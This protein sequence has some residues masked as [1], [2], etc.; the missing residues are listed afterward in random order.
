MNLGWLKCDKRSVM[1]SIFSKSH[2]V[3]SIRLRFNRRT[4]YFN[5]D[6]PHRETA[7]IAGRQETA[8]IAGAAVISGRQE[9]AIIAERQEAAIIAGAAVIIAGR[10]ET[11]I[12]AE[13]SNQHRRM[14]GDSHRR[15]RSSHHRR[16]PGNNHHRRFR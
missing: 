14:P 1:S 8:I 2:H 5:T 4:F 12:V 9:T 13:L 10:Q 15:R 16:M 7:I 6:H 3:T 11:A